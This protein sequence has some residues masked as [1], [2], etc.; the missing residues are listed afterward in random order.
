M[1]AG[2]TVYSSKLGASAESS[3][4]RSSDGRVAGDARPL[5]DPHRRPIVTARVVLHRTVVPHGD[6]VGC[7]AEPTLVLDD[8][9]L[10]AQLLD[11]RP[12]LLGAESDHVAG[13]E[14]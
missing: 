14:P 10:A 9:G 11:Q 8:L 13:E 4:A 1:C 7:P 3:A 5:H 2:R 6:R 12:A